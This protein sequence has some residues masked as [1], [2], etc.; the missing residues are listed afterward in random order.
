MRKGSNSSLGNRDALGR[1]SWILNS[2]F[3]P[4]VVPMDNLPRVELGFQAIAKLGVDPWSDNCCRFRNKRVVVMLVAMDWIS[5]LGAMLKLIGARKKGGTVSWK[6]ISGWKLVLI[7]ISAVC[8]LYACSWWS[9]DCGVAI[10][11]FNGGSG[12]RTNWFV[13]RDLVWKKHQR[14]SWG[15]NKHHFWV[16]GHGSNRGSHQFV[17]TWW[18]QVS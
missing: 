10:T 3:F 14:R 4:L 6:G 8:E 7:L 5:S 13:V 17:G 1:Q 11:G 12:I 9:F 2:Q 18:V 16:S 15:W